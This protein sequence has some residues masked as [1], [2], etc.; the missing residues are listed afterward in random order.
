MGSGDRKTVNGI[1]QTKSGVVATTPLADFIEDFEETS[2]LNDYGGATGAWSTQSSPVKYGSQSIVSANTDFNSDG[3]VHNSIGLHS[4]ETYR[5]YV[6]IASNTVPDGRM[7]FGAY[8]DATGTDSSWRQSNNYQVVVSY[9]SDEVQLIKDSSTLLAQN[10]GVGIPDGQMMYC[11]WKWDYDGTHTVTL[12]DDS[13]DSQLAQMSSTDSSYDNGYMGIVSDDDNNGI[14][15][16]ID[17]IIRERSGAKTVIDSFEAYSTSNTLLQE[18]TRWGQAGGFGSL[19]LQGTGARASQ[20]ASSSSTSSYIA[21]QST[22]DPSTTG[23]QSG[24][25]PYYPSADCT[26]RSTFTL[27]NSDAVADTGFAV[28]STASDFNDNCYRLRA[29]GSTSYGDKP[30]LRKTVGGS[31]TSLASFSTSLSTSTWYDAAIE[32]EDTGS[33]VN[34]TCRLWEWNGTSWVEHDSEI[35]GTDSNRDHATERGVGIALANSSTNP[36]LIDYYR[37]YDSLGQNSA[38]T[39]TPNN[40][41]P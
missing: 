34:L 10:T 36:S 20:S 5:F 15:Q 33:Q 28:P 19:N 30:F 7:Y 4:G 35:S 26:I 12:Y 23:S 25:F 31:S 39:W 2:P 6:H 37:F 40:A 29:G 22:T 13:D 32:F 9:E 16:T 14:D 1:V 8:Q 41:A 3:I 27:D 24:T 17:S 21:C 38:P 18:S 11:D